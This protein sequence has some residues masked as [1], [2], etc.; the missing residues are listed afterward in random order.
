MMII[1]MTKNAYVLTV[2]RRKV[3]IKTK[4]NE[5]DIRAKI[6]EIKGHA[7]KNCVGFD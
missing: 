7:A 3:N 1:W 5:E 6:D 2:V 4:M